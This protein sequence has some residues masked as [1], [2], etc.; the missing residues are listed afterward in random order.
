MRKLTYP[1]VLEPAG[2]G[3]YSVYFPDLPGCISYGKDFETALSEA[4]DAL[5]LHIYGMEK[6]GEPVPAPSKNPEVDPDTAP[7]YLVSPVSVYPELVSEEIDNRRVKM[8]VTIPAWVKELAAEKGLNSSRLLEA[9]ILDAAQVRRPRAGHAAGH[10]SVTSVYGVRVET[11]SVIF[12]NS[13]SNFATCIR[14]RRVTSALRLR[15]SYLAM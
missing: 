14:I 2:G 7:G 3:A 4:Q 8:N 10:S 11:S 15:S 1:A 13:R 5:G 6:D 12:P 9:A